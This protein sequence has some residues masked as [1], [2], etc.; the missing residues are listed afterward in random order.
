M[1]HTGIPKIINFV[2]IGGKPMPTWA[3]RNVRRFAELNPDYEILIHD[4]H[5]LR[6]EHAYAYNH[7]S[8]L[9]SKADLIRYSALQTHGGWY[10]DVDFTPFRPIDDIAN[11]YQLDGSKFFMT[12]QHGQMNPRLTVANGVLAATPDHPLWAEINRAIT[13]TNPPYDRCTFGPV[14]TTKL[15]RT[16][17][18]QITLGAWPFFYPASISEAVGVYHA[19]RQNGDHYAARIAPT[20]GQLPF[21]MHLW[22]NANKHDLT[23]PPRVVPTVGEFS[24]LRAVFPMLDCQRRDDTQPFRAIL[25]GLERIGFAVDAPD[26]GAPVKLA[27]ADLMVIWN[28]RKGKYREWADSAAKANIPTIHIEHG[29][30]D[31]R[32]YTQADHAGIL[33]WASWTDSL[34]R[35]APTSGADRLTA[36]WPY[37]PQSFTKRH[38][39]ILVIGQVAGDAQ[40]DDSEIQLSTPLEKM[41]AR[42]LPRGVKAVF[43]PHPV[44][45]QKL[46]KYMPRCTEPTIVDAI[47]QARFAVMINSNAGNECLAMGCPVL[48]FGPAV[49]A[50]A[51]VALQT[52]VADFQINFQRMLDGYLPDTAKVRNYLQ[53]LACRQWNQ[54]EW[55]DGKVL[56]S[57]VRKAM[58]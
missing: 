43:R 49:Y 36:V 16:H 53:R 56:A 44:S 2:W 54:G 18:N 11:A 24:G 15:Y 46:A 25:E 5:A 8:R 27:T 7:T 20:C 26:L 3:A 32:A 1:S 13:L 19:C 23:S 33:H 4:E 58:A 31:R 17:R 37:P 52:S 57:L 22:A 29:F 38:G 30:F 47:A 28:G 14:L 41:V 45:R 55:R 35:P 51:G 39:N 42:S 48:C 21:V 10:F 9:C 40:L 50:K 34:N 6:P 12:E